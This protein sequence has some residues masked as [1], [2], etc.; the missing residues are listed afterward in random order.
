M[1]HSLDFKQHLGQFR[2]CTC[3]VGKDGLG[4]GSHG[5]V[6]QAHT[7]G[8]TNMNVFIGFVERKKSETPK[9]QLYG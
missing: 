5:A 4:A 6:R 9:V 3:S 1:H 8:W 2:R 7:D